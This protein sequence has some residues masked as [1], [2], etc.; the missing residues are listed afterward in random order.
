MWYGT[1]SE[2]SPVSSGATEF[3]DVHIEGNG[4]HGLQCNKET[5]LTE[6]Y[7]AKLVLNGNNESHEGIMFHIYH[8]TVNP[9]WLGCQLRAHLHSVSNLWL[10]N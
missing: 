9:V 8:L 2:P 5:A 7:P 10:H 1:H 3:P 6:E 4:K